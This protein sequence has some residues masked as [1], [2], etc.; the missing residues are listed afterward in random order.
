MRVKF[1]VNLGSTDA[2]RV[3]LDFRDCVRDA[4]CEVPDRAGQ[5]LVSKGIA[6]DVSEAGAESGPPAEINGVPDAPEIGPSDE[7]EIKADAK[8]AGGRTK[9][10]D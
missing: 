5:W 8:P 7:P 1:R 6:T 2:S 10:Q 3:N 9:K 4:E